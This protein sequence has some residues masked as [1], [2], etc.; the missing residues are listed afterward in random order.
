MHFCKAWGPY[1][2]STPGRPLLDGAGIILTPRPS[3]KGAPSAFP[4]LM[5]FHL[6]MGSPRGESEKGSGGPSVHSCTFPPSPFDGIRVSIAADPNPSLR[7]LPCG[8]HPCRGPLTPERVSYRFD[9]LSRLL[10]AHFVRALA[11]AMLAGFPS[12]WDETC[13]PCSAL[14][15]NEG[16]RFGTLSASVGPDQR[17]FGIKTAR[18]SG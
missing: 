4:L 17:C 14:V 15:G 8:C 1:V 10:P 5:G 2:A 16:A 6:L 11:G 9:A 12:G 7:V 18:L 13:P 3:Q